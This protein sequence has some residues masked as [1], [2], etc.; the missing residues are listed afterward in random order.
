M[1]GTGTLILLIVAGGLLVAAIGVSIDIYIW[2]LP[3]L[4]RIFEERPFF[5]TE[6]GV[7]FADAEAVSF[8]TEDGMT[9]Q[10]SY[11][12]CGGASRRGLIVFCHE[13]LSNRWSA[14]EYCAPLHEAGFDI[15]T[16]DFRN[17]GDSDALDGYE[18]LQWVTDYEVAD[19]RAALQ[20]AENRGGPGDIGLFGISRGGAAAICAAALDRQVRAVATDGAF[21]TSGTQVHYIYRWARIYSPVHWLFVH[22]PRWYV[23]A[24]AWMTCRQVGRRRRCRFTSVERAMVRLRDRPLL[25][26]HGQR[27]NYIVPEIVQEMLRFTRSKAQLW[28]APKAKHNQ[29][30]ATARDEYTKRLVDFFRRHLGRPDTEDQQEAA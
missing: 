2:Y 21:P 30:L 18:P 10:G 8:G 19:V 12:R 3:K 13:F 25:M 24:M 16:F 15:L 6:E 28:I 4:A 17:H 9:L 14:A 29:A 23:R 27:D 5:V 7:P 26:I 1:F 20:Y 11:W 22:F